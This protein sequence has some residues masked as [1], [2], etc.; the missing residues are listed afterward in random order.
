MSTSTSKNMSPEAQKLNTE[1][2]ALFD[3]SKKIH[4]IHTNNNKTQCLWYSRV[5]TL[6]SAYIK[7][8]R[9]PDKW[10]D[11][12]EKF[13]YKYKSDL[14]KDIFLGDEDTMGVNDEW[15]KNTESFE[16]AKKSKKA[17][18]AKSGWG[19]KQMTCK[20]HVIYFDP[21]ITAASIPIAL[22][23]AWQEGKVKS[24]D[25]V[26]LAAFGSGFTWGSVIIRW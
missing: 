12:M 10:N 2:T 18:K 5:T 7:S 13:F 15:I 8:K 21:K 3:I 9:R 1:L 17:K 11:M 6:Q 14:V 22:T 23:E 26:V 4:K 19:S 25:L 20:G 24:G 16:G